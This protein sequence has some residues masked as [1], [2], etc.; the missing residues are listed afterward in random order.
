MWRRHLHQRNHIKTKFTLLRIYFNAVCQV[1]RWILPC[2]WIRWVIQRC[3]QRVIWWQWGQH[4]DD[5]L[6]DITSLV[7]ICLIPEPDD[8]TDDASNESCEDK[9][10]DEI[11]IVLC[12][13]RTR[14]SSLVASI[15]THYY[16]LI[17][18]LWLNVFSDSSLASFIIFI[19]SET[20]ECWF[21]SGW[22][23]RAMGR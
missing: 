11:I 8:S 22:N 14:S 7:G 17:A 5:L 9:D 13:I 10:S 21:L 20:C 2:T 19:T 15:R 16:S 18:S 3:F 12:A 1:L 4:V 23:R 6:D